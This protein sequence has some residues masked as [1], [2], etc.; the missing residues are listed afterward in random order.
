MIVLGLQVGDNVVS[1]W[2]SGLH[3]DAGRF[4][5]VCAGV[6]VD[7]ERLVGIRGAIE[8]GEWQSATG[9]TRRR[10][11]M[12]GE[13][14]LGA[15]RSVLGPLEGDEHST[16]GAQAGEEDGRF[17]SCDKQLSSSGR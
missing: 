3:L 5:A 2:S 17:P 16:R 12:A 4:G 15:Y 13:G 8:A 14:V 7:C 10:R 6:D 11:Y 9:V 1:I